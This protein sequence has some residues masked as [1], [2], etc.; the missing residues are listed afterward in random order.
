MNDLT[1]TNRDKALQAMQKIELEGLAEIDRICR[2]YDIKYSL[3]GGTCLGQIRHGGIIPWDDDIDVDMTVDNY[4]RF[5]EVAPKELE[6]SHFFLRCRKTDPTH[7][8]SACRL[9]NTETR[10]SLPRWSSAHKEAGV[11][12]D[13]FRW[14]YLPDNPEERKKLASRLFWIHCMQSYKEYGKYAAKLD[15]KYRIPLRIMCA[16]VPTK[17]LEDYEEKVIHR[18]KDKTGWIIDDAIIHG[19]HGGYLS[20]GIDEY[21]DVM[22][23]GLKVMNKKNSHNFLRTIYGEDYN[24]WLPPEKEYPT[25]NGPR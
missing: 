13:I 11:F 17:K 8:R 18:H 23:E 14:N 20:D 6:G 25:T 9:E 24:T 12:V 2:K 21:E 5:V 10:L 19:D 15:K 1:I 22:F 3:G 7:L 4:D 16:L